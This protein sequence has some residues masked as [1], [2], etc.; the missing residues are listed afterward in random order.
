MRLT[1]FSRRRICEMPKHMEIIEAS[2]RSVWGPVSWDLIENHNR[3]RR[4]QE[5]ADEV[6]LECLPSLCIVQTKAMMRFLLSF[7]HHFAGRS[8]YKPHNQKKV[9]FLGPGKQSQRRGVVFTE[10]LTRVHSICYAEKLMFAMA[11]RKSHFP[12]GLI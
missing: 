5:K 7:H 8:T 12:T 1:F 10:E 2:L 6:H 4:D 3:E 11:Q 9:H